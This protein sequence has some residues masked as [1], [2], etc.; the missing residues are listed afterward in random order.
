MF[1]LILATVFLHQT[2]QPPAS[3]DQIISASAK[4]LEVK[5]LQT[6]MLQKTLKGQ[7]TALYKDDGEPTL[8]VYNYQVTVGKSPF[9]FRSEGTLKVGLEA[10]LHTFLVVG[11]GKNITVYDQA[12]NSY[13]IDPIRASPLSG[14]FHMGML[15]PIYLGIVQNPTPALSTPRISDTQAASEALAI[16]PKLFAQQG[17]VA[18]GTRQ[19]PDGRSSLFLTVKTTNPLTPSTFTL[20]L[21]KE[22]TYLE[23][24]RTEMTLEEKVNLTLTDVIESITPVTSLPKFSFQIPRRAKK[25][26][27]LPGLLDSVSSQG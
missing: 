17:L 11:D 7:L 18:W 26:K 22:K 4:A 25:V 1:S 2:P 23:R 24:F 14:I 21:N 10:K 27:E 5:T 3:D 16:F 6:L 12:N 20:T 8:Y 13:T 9:E 19:E 15:S